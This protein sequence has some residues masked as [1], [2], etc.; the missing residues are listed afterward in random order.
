ME[1]REVQERVARVE[2][3]L[4]E[5]EADPKATEVVQALV[6][7]YGEALARLLA[8]ADPVEDELVSHLLLVH[9]LHPVN[10]ETR[11]QRALDEV[12]PYLG[13]HGGDVELLGIEGG[14]A[15]LRLGGSCDG[16]ASSA[17]TMQLAIEDAVRAAAPE[18]ESVEAE[19]V[20]EP[21][22]PGLLQ[23]G[24][25]PPQQ[26]G[27]TVVGA[28]PQ[29]ADGGIHVTEVASRPLLFLELDG[30]FYAYGERCPACS[31]SLERA[32]LDGDELACA[33]GQRYDV[34]RAGRSQ[35]D[36]ERSLEPIPLLVDEAGLVKVAVAAGIT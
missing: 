26:P 8:G 13:S 33:C 36:S 11:V 10:V 32:E 20:A 7:L 14:V 3:L 18:L 35:D 30:T 19:G 9:D 5:I 12:R 29:L 27:W 25:L 24:S 17:A 6:D 34:R 21:Q 1:N 31:G 4:G 28:L 15:H 16:C 23:I 2:A 22:Q